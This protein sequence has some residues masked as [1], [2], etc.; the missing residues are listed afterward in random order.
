MVKHH[1]QKQLREERVYFGSRLQREESIRDRTVWQWTGQAWWENQAETHL[2]SICTQEAE[3]E[4]EQEVINTLCP[5]WCTSFSTAPPL[6]GSMT[7]PNSTPTG[8]QVLEFMSLWGHPL[9]KPPHIGRDCGSSQHKTS[10]LYTPAVVTN[11]SEWYCDGWQSL[12]R[13]R[14][15]FSIVQDLAAHWTDSE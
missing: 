1:D 13:N 10:T 11:H 4:R 14:H 3:R 15:L 7:F 5:H 9:L 8:D 2:I 12:D 6:K